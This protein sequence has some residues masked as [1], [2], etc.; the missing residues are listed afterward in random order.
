M[1]VPVT[2]FRGKT[3]NIIHSQCV[4]VALFIHHAKRMRLI[5]LSYVA[6]PALPLISVVSHKQHDFSKKIIEHK[7]YASIST[8]KFSEAFLILRRIKR[9]II[10][11]VHGF[12]G[13]VPV[14][15]SDVNKS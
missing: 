10:I 13:R 14:I 9:D 15:F 5:I 6:R 7:M 8:A 2:I 3:I 4:S 1:A 12:P 11:N